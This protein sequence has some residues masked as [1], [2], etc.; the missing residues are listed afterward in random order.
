MMIVSPRLIRASRIMAALAGV[1]AV[2]YLAMEVLVFVVPGVADAIGGIAAHA[3]VPIRESVPLVYRLSALAFDLIP[4]ALVVW[5]LIEL[6]RLFLLYAKGE[7]F[8]EAALRSLNRVA[9]LMFVEVVVAF[10]IQAPVSYLISLAN[11]PGQHQV[12]LG[13]GSNDVS[14]LFMAGVV[15]V[16]AR[17]MAEARRVSEENASFV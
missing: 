13:F 3:S 11:P 16:I 14:F 12:S 4:T 15:L 1:G 5:A 2:L 6:R 7:V 8:S 9:M 10:F 17:V